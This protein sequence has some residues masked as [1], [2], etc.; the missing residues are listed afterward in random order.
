MTTANNLADRASQV[1]TTDN[2]GIESF[3]SLIGGPRIRISNEPELRLQMK[4]LDE[5]CE[6]W[7]LQRYAEEDKGLL[8]SE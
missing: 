3:M 2:D 8:G 5:D 6:K 1:S 7:R 4:E